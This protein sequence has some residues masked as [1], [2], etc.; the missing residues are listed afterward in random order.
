[1][2]IQ[3]PT[4]L[5]DKERCLKN[6]QLM[7]D[8][9]EQNQIDL[10]PHFKTHQS[11]E[12][13]RWF[14]DLG[15]KKIAVSSL[16]MAAYFAAD[17]WEDITVAFPANILEIDL[18]NSLA[19]KIKLNLLIQS[20]ETLLFLE[21]YLTAPICGFI[22]IDLGTKRTGI[23]GDNFE[24]L[25]DLIHTIERSRQLIFSGFLGHAGHSYAAQGLEEIKAVH[26]EAMAKMSLVYHY[27]QNTHPNISISIGDTPTCSR[28]STFD[29]VTELR[30]GNFVFYDLTQTKIGACSVDQIAVAVACPIVALH[31]ERN[32]IIIYGGGVHFSKEVYLHPDYGTCYGLVVS[33][34][35]NGWDA[36]IPKVYISKLS[37]EHG[38][39]SCSDAFMESCSIGQVLKILPVHSCMTANLLQ[40]MFTTEGE[41]IKMMPTLYEPL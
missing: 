16:K 25:D 22:K 5:L 36:P 14:R 41:H 21:T 23:E 8:K 33:D 15:V 19:S 34:D 37:Q 40:Q 27:Y 13:G 9:A 20:K 6:I 32:E 4:L 18:I 38:T 10:R 35:K 30:P 11:H 24:L 39:I 28:M 31:P 26:D 1:M 12:V 7:L 3:R 2:H 29:F 17:G